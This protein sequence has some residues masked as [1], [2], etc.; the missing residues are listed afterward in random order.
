MQLVVGLIRVVKGAS[1]FKLVRY[2]AKDLARGLKMLKC[3]ERKL[4]GMRMLHFR[5]NGIGMSVCRVG[6][7]AT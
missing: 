7:I 5:G 3:L 4:V 6:A 2:I 1:I